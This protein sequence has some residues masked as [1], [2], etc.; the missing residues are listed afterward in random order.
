MATFHIW[1]SE[2]MCVGWC[3]VYLQLTSFLLFT[4]KPLPTT[5]Q[6]SLPLRRGSVWLCTFIVGSLSLPSYCT[7]VAVLWEST[8]LPAIFPCIILDSFIFL[9]IGSFS[10]SFFV[11]NRTALD[12]SP[13]C[14]SPPTGRRCLFSVS[15]SWIYSSCEGFW[16][17]LFLNVWMLWPVGISVHQCVP[18]AFRCQ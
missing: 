11:P 8:A 1:Y 7:T 9:F 6:L 10:S 12:S 5:H 4:E 15:G 3:Q 17:Y 14:I 2:H 13:L 16:F 18:D